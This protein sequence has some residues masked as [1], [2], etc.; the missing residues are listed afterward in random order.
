MVVVLR[1]L[2]RLLRLGGTWGAPGRVWPAVFRELNTIA[3][4]ILLVAAIVPLV[5]WRW[6]RT[7]GCGCLPGCLDVFGVLAATGIIGKVLVG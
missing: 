1:A 2:S 6:C 3:S 7:H 5:M 4:I